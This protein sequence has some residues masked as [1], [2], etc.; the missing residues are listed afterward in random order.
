M[1]KRKRD[2][3]ET[4]I[5]YDYLNWYNIPGYDGMYQVN[6]EGNIRSYNNGKHGIRKEPRLLNIY[7]GKR[8]A[9]CCTLRKDGKRK[10]VYVSHIMAITFFGGIPKGKYVCHKNHDCTDNC[11]NN[12]IFRTKK[13]HYTER[14]FCYNRKPVLKIDKKGNIIDVYRSIAEAARKNYMDSDQMGKHVHN[15]LKNPLKFQD[16]IFCLEENYYG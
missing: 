12:L 13:E 14:D 16:Y 10:T 15:M 11:L 4:G 2:D 1:S 6:T 5:N 7:K 8:G 3:Y 9:M